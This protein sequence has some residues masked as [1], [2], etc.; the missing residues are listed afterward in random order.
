MASWLNRRAASHEPQGVQ[1]AAGWF[2]EVVQ[3]E[4]VFLALIWVVW[5]NLQ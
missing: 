2:A 4:F 1:R 3:R 5:S